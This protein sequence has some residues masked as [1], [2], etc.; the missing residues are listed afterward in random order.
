VECELSKLGSLSKKNILQHV[1]SIC[2]RNRPGETTYG[3][4]GLMIKY[5]LIG[6]LTM[7][8]VFGGF[9]YF[10]RIKN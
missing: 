1:D 8:V 5:F 9:L 6:L 7:T 4:L 10:R 2:E 3:E